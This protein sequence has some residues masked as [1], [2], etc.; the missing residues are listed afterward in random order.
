MSRIS[1]ARVFVELDLLTD[2][3]SFIVINLPNGVILKQPVIYE[4]LPRFCKLCK[5]LGHN[6]RTCTSYHAPVVK[7]LGKKSNP[8][9]TTNRGRSVFDHLGTVIELSLGKTKGQIGETSQNYDPMT[10]EAAVASD[11]WEVVK[12][13]KARKSLGILVGATHVADQVLTTPLKTKI[14]CVLANSSWN[15]LQLTFYIHLQPPGAFSDHS[16]AHIHIGSNCPPGC[17]PFKFFNMWVEHLEYAGLISD[18]WQLLVKGTPMFVLCKKLKS[19][20]QPLKSLNKLHYSHISE[21]VA[22]MEADLEQHQQ[23]LHDSRDDIY[24]LNRVN[25]LKI[26]LINLKSAEKAFFSQKLKCTFFKD[27]DRVSL[28]LHRLYLLLMRKLFAVALVLMIINLIFF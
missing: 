6:T 20:K 22:R 25:T 8:P 14:D 23:L 7:P 12:S 17:R 28:A 11:G 19:L 21:R 24:V 27:S 26:N 1:Y 4:M 10:I 3:K 2:L 9:I 16:G 15:N 5:V 18:G 13:K